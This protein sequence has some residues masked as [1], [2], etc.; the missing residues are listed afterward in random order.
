MTLDFMIISWNLMKIAKY[1]TK[2]DKNA[3]LR[4]HVLSA[5]MRQIILETLLASLSLFA[6]GCSAALR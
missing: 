1:V 5:P 2:H 6:P 3:C 4:L